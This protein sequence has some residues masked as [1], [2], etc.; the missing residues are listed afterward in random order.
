[1]RSSL[2]IVEYTHFLAFTFHSKLCVVCQSDYDI[3]V[4]I[5]VWPGNK[6]PPE[7]LIEIMRY[8]LFFSPRQYYAILQ[9][10]HGNFVQS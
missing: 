6:Y 1:M 7:L 4:Y 2:V 9:M 10:T 8:I 5:S 3:M